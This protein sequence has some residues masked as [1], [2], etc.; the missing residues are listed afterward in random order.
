ML[1]LVG[2]QS[3]K[4]FFLKAVKSVKL[5]LVGCQAVKCC[6]LHVVRQ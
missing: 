1:F 5:C 4:C 6:L 3:V 2:S